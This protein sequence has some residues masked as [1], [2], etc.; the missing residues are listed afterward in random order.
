MYFDFSTSAGF[1]CPEIL[2]PV[3]YVNLAITADLYNDDIQ[4]A[5]DLTFIVSSG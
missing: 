1:L 4:L 2:R 3:A 5:C